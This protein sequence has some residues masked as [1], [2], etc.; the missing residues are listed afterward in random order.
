MSTLD[1]LGDDYFMH[2]RGT[3]IAVIRQVRLP[4]FNTTVW[5]VLTPD[6]KFIGFFPTLQIAATLTWELWVERTSTRG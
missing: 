1:R 6:E 3:R 4:R 2:D 5:R